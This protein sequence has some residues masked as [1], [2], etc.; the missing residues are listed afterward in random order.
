MVVSGTAPDVA[1]I[2][3]PMDLKWASAGWLMDL[4]DYSQNGLEDITREFGYLTPNL[5]SN[6]EIVLDDEGIR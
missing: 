5:S 4:S 3:D 1:Y 2:P 6:F